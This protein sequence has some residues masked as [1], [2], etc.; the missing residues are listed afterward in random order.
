MY[1][2][3][4]LIVNKSVLNWIQVCQLQCKTQVQK[5]IDLNLV[6]VVG[7]SGGDD[8]TGIGD[9]I[10]GFGVVVCGACT[11]LLVCRCCWC[12]C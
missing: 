7:V 11:E 5:S 10:G 1:I 12:C 9:V 3:L 4:P 6:V 8:G 2:S